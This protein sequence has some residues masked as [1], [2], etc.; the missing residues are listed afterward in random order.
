MPLAASPA[1]RQGKRKG[2]SNERPA[3]LSML[4][5]QPSA[6]ALLLQE[7][8]GCRSAVGRDGGCV[9]RGR[10]VEVMPTSSLRR[11]CEAGQTQYGDESHEN[12]AHFSSSLSGRER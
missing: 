10:E 11:G 7:W 12:L 6:A 2:R 8:L 3:D 1:T 9:V 5:F 4:Y